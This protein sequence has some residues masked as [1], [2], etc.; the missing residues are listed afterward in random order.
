V[1]GYL[2][3]AYELLGIAGRKALVQRYQ[4]GIRRSTQHRRPA[5]VGASREH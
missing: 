5:G 2:H 3:E 1:R 4:E